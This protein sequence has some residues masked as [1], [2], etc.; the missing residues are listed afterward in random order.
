[1][2]EISVSFT[3]VSVLPY[4]CSY[5]S[6][7]ISQNTG[8]KFALRIQGDSGG[9]VKLWEVIVLIFVRKKVHMNMCLILC[10]YQERT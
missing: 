10:G 5:T 4:L 7:L 1:M 8:Q 3:L 6:L 2:E 9:K